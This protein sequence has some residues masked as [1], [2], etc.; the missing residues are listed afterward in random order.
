MTIDAFFRA[1]PYEFK[2]KQRLARLFFSQIIENQKDIVVNTDN[3][4][5]KLPN[6][7]EPVSFSLFINGLFEREVT[8]FINK[9]LVGKKCFLDIGANI[10]SIAIPVVNRNPHLKTYCIEASPRVFGYLKHNQS[11]NNLTNMQVYNIAITDKNIAEI[12]FFSPEEGFGR[13]SLSPV[14]TKKAETVEGITLDDFIARHQIT[15]PD[16]IKIDIEG[17]EKQAFVG[18]KN[19]LSGKDA[20]NILFEFCDWAEELAGNKKGDSQ[21]VLL[22][23]GYQLFALEED[24]LKPLGKIMESDFAMIYATK[25]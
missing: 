5:Y 18:G 15:K 23:Y 21:R 25:N 22:D 6:L 16:F 19:L 7:K 2:G 4:T 1:L 8:D 11:V 17:Y 24:I 13:G 9:Q 20:P 3:G 12:A 14:F 10:G